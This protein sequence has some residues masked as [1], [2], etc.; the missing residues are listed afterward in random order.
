VYAGVEL[1]DGSGHVELALSYFKRIHFFGHFLLLVPLIRL[2]DGLQA[3]KA[4]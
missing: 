2:T 4:S 3:R 1:E